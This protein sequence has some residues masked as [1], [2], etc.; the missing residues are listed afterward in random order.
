MRSDL[1]TQG[2]DRLGREPGWKTIVEETIPSHRI[3]LKAN[4]CRSLTRRWN[5]QLGN[6]NLIGFLVT[7]LRRQCSMVLS[8]ISKGL[9][10]ANAPLSLSGA[11]AAPPAPSPGRRAA[12]PTFTP[13]S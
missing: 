12:L 11:Q 9:T 2:A 6:D 8:I 1:C 5:F 13:H 3:D 4:F 10:D 7:A